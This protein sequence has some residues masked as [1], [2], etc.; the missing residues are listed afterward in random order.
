MPQVLEAEAAEEYHHAE[1]V[2]QFIFYFQID[3]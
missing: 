3:S 1:Q 2:A